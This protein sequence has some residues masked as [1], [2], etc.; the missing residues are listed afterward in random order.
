MVYTSNWGII[1]TYHL[2][3]EPETTIELP[4]C[5]FLG[6]L[7]LDVFRQRLTSEY[8]GRGGRIF[9]KVVGMAGYGGATLPGSPVTAGSPEN[10]S[11]EIPFIGE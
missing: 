9:G 2:L 3:G 1:C 11:L 7:H 10:G 6:L 8:G 4:R 5:G